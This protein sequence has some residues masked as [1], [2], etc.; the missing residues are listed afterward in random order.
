MKDKISSDIKKMA[1]LLNEMIDL[2]YKGFMENQTHYLDMAL[3][4][5]RIL[6]DLE[7]NITQTVIK[8][9]K[10]GD[11]KLFKE[12]VF[13]EQAAQHIERMGDELRSI[14]ERMEI[15]II[16]K[17]YFSDIGVE[18]Y[19]DIYE[20]MKRSFS[21]TKEFLSTSHENLLDMILSN[22]D[23]IKES[24]GKYRKEHI[25]RLAKGLCEP[26]AANMFFDMLDF[27]GNIARHC[28]NIAK[29]YKER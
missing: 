16:E 10:S 29:T 23:I 9:S 7:K 12:L 27:T 1:E 15:K 13:L 18:Q 8:G 3:N 4:K 22:G 11:E 25:N 6:D 21:L 20:K 24:I 14:M 2:A 17:L 26:R 28:T 5:E 19:T